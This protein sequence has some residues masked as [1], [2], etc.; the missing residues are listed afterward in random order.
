MLFFTYTQD[1]IVNAQRIDSLFVR[2]YQP[3]NVASDYRLS[4]NMSFGLPWRKLKSRI[5]LRTEG[6]A[7]TGT[8]LVAP[9]E[10]GIAPEAVDRIRRE[11]EALDWR[12][13]DLAVMPAPRD[14]AR[15]G[16]SSQAE[17]A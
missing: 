12:L 8:I 13:Y 6:R 5:N 11:V 16:V 9:R 17:L 15:L 1:R 10:D 2:H 7:I 3:V 4:G 14:D